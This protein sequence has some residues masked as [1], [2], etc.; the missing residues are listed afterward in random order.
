MCRP[1]QAKILGKLLKPELAIWQRVGQL[2]AAE[3][4]QEIEAGLL[5]ELRC[6]VTQFIEAKI[7]ACA[8]RRQGNGVAAVAGGEH[9]NAAI[10]GLFQALDTGRKGLVAAQ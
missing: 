1:I 9:G 6:P 10:E 7:N 5:F 3:G 8:A 2:Q 4:G